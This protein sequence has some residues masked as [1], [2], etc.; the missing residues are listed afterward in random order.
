MDQPEFI[1]FNILSISSCEGI[2]MWDRLQISSRSICF[3][4]KSSFIL[5]AF[6]W[7]SLLTSVSAL[8]FLKKIQNLLP[9]STG[10]WIICNF[11]MSL[12]CCIM[13]R[14]RLPGVEISFD[15]NDIKAVTLENLARSF[16]G[17]SMRFHKF[18]NAF[19]SWW[20][21][22]YTHTVRRVILLILLIVLPVLIKQ[23]R[24]TIWPTWIMFLLQF[25]WLVAF[26]Y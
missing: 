20:S 17:V 25:A 9:R 10:G 23:I 1:S 24:D 15:D 6:S 11:I 2:S 5:L 12:T 3:L 22:K 21:Y 18:V 7:S 14:V 4:R 8:E 19:P 13:S 26:Q 16:W